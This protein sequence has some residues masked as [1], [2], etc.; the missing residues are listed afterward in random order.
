MT[1]IGP[2]APN[3]FVNATSIAFS[4]SDVRGAWNADIYDLRGRL[5]RRL[6]V[7]SGAGAGSLTWDGT[8]TNGTAASSGVYFVRLSGDGGVAQTQVVKLN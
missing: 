2:A 7:P 6:D 4:V 8:N 5:V 1:S 3:P